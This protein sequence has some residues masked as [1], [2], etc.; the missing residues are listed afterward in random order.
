LPVDNV[1][2]HR[3]LLAMGTLPT[4]LLL[5][6]LTDT[7]TRPSA[8]VLDLKARQGVGTDVAA[9]LADSLTV[10]L[11]KSQRFSRVVAASELAETLGYEQQK[12]AANCEDTSCLVEIAGAL[13][14]DLLIFGNVGRVGTLWVI[15]LKMV[16]ARTGT[17]EG[18]ASRNLP[19]DDE[20]VLLLAMK[21]VVQELLDPLPASAAEELAV[22][23][24][25]PIFKHA[26]VYPTLGVVLCV[27]V[28]AAA[29]SAG[30]L[31]CWSVYALSGIDAAGTAVLTVAAATVAAALLGVL[32]SV[33]ALALV[34][35]L[36]V[37]TLVAGR[38]RFTILDQLIVAGAGA[39]AVGTLGLGFVAFC[40]SLAAMVGGLANAFQTGGSDRLSGEL[41]LLSGVTG[42]MAL[43]LLAGAVL[44]GGGSVTS[45]AAGT[46]LPAE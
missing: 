7:D 35:S 13:G 30:A 21:S 28:C 20:T 12:Q 17:S 10:N 18:S 34:V 37:V 5:A 44:V 36:P 27:P 40:A 23:P 8:A 4:L 26:W 24:P 3:H 14:V 6:A 33:P 16:N 1:C 25:D 32:T 46:L 29:M 19:G 15:N 31:G 22:A 2:Q 38:G 42:V 45:L 43:G 11:R 9:L 41:V 39:V